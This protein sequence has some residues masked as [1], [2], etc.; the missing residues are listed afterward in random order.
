MEKLISIIMPFYNP[1]VE[2]FRNSIN[3]VIKQDYANFE[4]LLINDG[5]KDEY[6]SI[7][8]E[9]CKLDVRCKLVTKKNGGVSSAR[10][11]GLKLAEGEYIAFIDSDDWVEHNFISRMIEEIKNKDLVICSVATQDFIVSDETVKINDFYSHP[12]KYSGLQYINFCANKLFRSEII[13]HNRIFFNESISLG[14]DALFLSDYLEKCKII[15][16]VSAGLYHYTPNSNSAV[17]RFNPNFWYMEEQVIEI[18]LGRFHNHNLDDFEKQF[19]DIWL[20]YKLKNVL[21]YYLNEKTQYSKCILSKI[22]SCRLY[23]Y[24]LNKEL[25]YNKVMEIK[26]KFIILL[27]KTLGFKGIKLTYIITRKLKDLQL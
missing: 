12:S 14:E 4:L 26:D 23:R 1:P 18:Q 7:A 3:S 10:N 2:L 25:S 8:L 9:Y 5:S 21:Y 20:F 17:A 6:K 19:L 22:R 15:Q 11:V 16:C 24:L 13:H 27:W